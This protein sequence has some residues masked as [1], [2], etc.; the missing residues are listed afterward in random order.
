M[1]LLI[2]LLSMGVKL[3]LLTI[4]LGHVLICTPFAVAILSSAFQS[5]D[6]SLEEAALD[7]GET[8]WSTFRLIVLPLSHIGLHMPKTADIVG[9]LCSHI[10]LF[11]WAIAL[12]AVR[13]GRMRVASG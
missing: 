7:L 3:S 13:A 10:F 6:K 4:I 8:G 11:G 2:V 12:G 1:S 9:E 5:L